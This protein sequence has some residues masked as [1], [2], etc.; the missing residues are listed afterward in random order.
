MTSLASRS[1]NSRQTLS[2][3]ISFLKILAIFHS[4]PTNQ[5]HLSSRLQTQAASLVLFFNLSRQIQSCQRRPRRSHIRLHFRFDNL[6]LRIFGPHLFHLKTSRSLFQIIG[7]K[8][9]QVADWFTVTIGY[10]AKCNRSIRKF[11]GFCIFC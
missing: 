1:A 4:D 7:F 5:A 9:N 10:H 2:V 3:L 6:M 11:N 8:C